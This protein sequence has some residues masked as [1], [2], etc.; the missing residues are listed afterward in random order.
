MNR[1]NFIKLVSVIGASLAIPT[2][3]LAEIAN[4]N[5]E[6]ISV[7]DN[8]NNRGLTAGIREALELILE[9]YQL[10][11]NSDFTRQNIVSDV[12][13]ILSKFIGNGAIQ[14]YRVDCDESNNSPTDINNGKLTVDLYLKPNRALDFI[15]IKGTLLS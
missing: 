11:P 10:E 8:V 4:T 3:L 1:R 12:R 9:E 2:S 7:L 13:D 15:K 5:V 14:G 6:N